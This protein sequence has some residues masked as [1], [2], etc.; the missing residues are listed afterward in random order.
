MTTSTPTTESLRELEN[1]LNKRLPGQAH[2]DALSRVLYSSDASTHQIEPL[3]VVYP[4]S[5]DDLCAA[6]E[7]AAGLKIPVLPRGAGTGLA[8]QTI[9]A[10]LIIDCARH[11]N[12]V[13]AMDHETRSAE[14]EPGV[15]GGPFNRQAAALGLQYGPDPASLERA[16]FGGMIGNN[17]TGAHSIRYGMTSDHVLA[18]DAV[19]SDGSAALFEAQTEA[20]AAA[21][22]KTPSLEGR[23]YAEA[24]RQRET[25]AQAIEQDWPRVWRRASG[26]SL[27]YLTGFTPSTPPAWYAPDEPYFSREGF[28]LA[29]V[30]TGSEGT[31]VVIRKA[32]VRLVPRPAATVLVVLAFPSTVA[33]CE[34]VPELLRAQPGAMELFP[35][36]L[37]EGARRVPTL[38]RRVTFVTADE[39]GPEAALLVAEFTGD[40][41]AEA[42]AAAGRLHGRGRVLVDPAQQADLWAVRAGGMGIITNI[43]GD[44]RPLDFI[45]DVSVP[46]ERLGEYV[47][48]VDAIL[49]EHG[50]SGVWYAHASAGCLHFRPMIN[51]RT[52]QGLADMRS[53]AEK[54]AAVAAN[55]RG[56]MS[57]EHGDGLARSE[58]VSQIFGPRLTQAFTEFKHAFDPNNLLNPGKVLPAP[59]RGLDRDLRYTPNYHTI[60]VNTLFAY[61]HETNLA[62]AAEACVG[63]GVCL[64]DGGVMCPSYQATRDEQHVTRGRANALRAALSGRLPKGA[65]TS[66]QMHQVLDLCLECKGCKAE[67]PA[68]VD[69]ARMK[70]E[71]LNLYQAEHGV[72]ARS[73]LFG[74]I[75][76]VSR[77][78]RPVA[79]LANWFNGLPVVR[80]IM[81]RTVGIAH[82]RP[83][84]QFQSHTFRDWFK[85]RPASAAA[86]AARPGAPAV[87]LFVDTYTEYNHPALGQAAVRLLEAAGYTVELIAQQGCCGRPMISKGLL[88]SARAAAARNIEALAPY[89]ARGLPVV[90]LE[91]SC[92]L[93]LRDEYL[94]FLPDDPRAEAVARASFLIEEFLT[95]P[96]ADGARPVDRLRFQKPQA[97]WLLHG[98]CH[99][100]SLVGTAPTLA[101]LRATGAE[102]NEIASGCCGMAGS[103]GYEAEHYEI[104]MQ[105]GGLK[106]FPAVKAG[107]QAGARITAHG[108]SC[109]A[110]IQEGTGVEAR[111]P[112]E[113]LADCLES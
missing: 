83:L 70:A 44:M 30:L 77:A 57:G 25:Y 64:Q 109:R 51:L 36:A 88:D 37:I 76:A 78:V 7:A 46:V 21:K 19:L 104:S 59:G 6:V 111:H 105:I 92:Q 79:G 94:E 15:A 9:G 26:Y 50:T 108:V 53:I 74:Q 17:S 66:P 99:A 96:G 1:Q 56:A 65:L 90:G 69:M 93:T 71:F 2:F 67:C 10:A 106:L 113:M 95:Q 49:A 35:G 4:R 32:R 73:R 85:A 54:T 81:E 22:A 29:P 43:P 27:N 23:I 45:E 91:P 87:A 48:R 68:T 89:V 86:P 61:R 47:T 97:P 14:V 33:A 5:A 18:L 31:L 24:L 101:L 80:Q 100:K 58:F 11:L 60:P 75:N 3:G 52:A 42:L 39:S 38:A 62:G 20:A 28:N 98:H 63:A 40:T 13:L 84:P 8:G 82:Q 112:I 72:P 12:R 16:T 107:I 110:Q 34:A 41:P 102:V 103:F 55:L